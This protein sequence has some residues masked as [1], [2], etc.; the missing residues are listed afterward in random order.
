MSDSGVSGGHS[1]LS[2]NLK[3][4]IADDIFNVFLNLDDFADWHT[5]NGSRL[6]CLIDKNNV[7]MRASA[8]RR[9]EGVREDSFFLYIHAE[10]FRTPPEPN[11]EIDIDGK[12]YAIR[13][14][15]DEM[16]LLVIEYG[17]VFGR[18]NPISGNAPRPLRG[19]A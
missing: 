4:Q 10:E 19:G 13:S 14:V 9:T 5:V 15:S 2:F 8:G 17:R 3:D 1:P 12:K 11:S 18:G 16:D 7:H 6:K